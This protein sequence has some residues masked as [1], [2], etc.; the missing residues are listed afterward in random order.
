MR[1]FVAVAALVSALVV[2]AGGASGQIS[3]GALGEQRIALVLA[4]WGPQ[5]VDVAAARQAVDET[6]AFVREASFGKT[7]LSVDVK[8]WLRALTRRP[9]GCDVQGVNETI[10]RSVDL[11]DYDLVAYLVPRL[12]CPW[13]G[14]YYPPGVWMLG[15]ISKNLFAHELGHNWGVREE[16]PAWVCGRPCAA[17]N[18]ADPYSVMG[19][20]S[21]HFGAFEKWRFGWIE[22][23][24]PVLED[25][26]YEIARIDRPSTRPHALYV[27]SGA[28]EYWVEYRPEVPWPVVHAGASTVRVTPSRFPQRNL[29]LA[30]ARSA[31]FAVAGAFEVVRTGADDERM[32]LRFRWTD[33]T[34]PARPRIESRVAGRTVTLRFPAADTGSGVER[35]ELAVGRGIR[36]AVPTSELQ[37]RELVG[38]DAFFRVRLGR[39]AHRV[40]VT[41]IDRAGNRSPTATRTVRIP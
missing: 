40:A 14:A 27:L 1:S 25:G 26:E 5:P 36:V 22:R 20:G 3:D 11:T 34:R 9:T 30:G 21:G 23:V 18:Y 8:G 32:S 4:T 33:R 2:Q 6:A 15:E 37:G 31:R 28:E 13:T 17:E 10:Q 16:G 29:L 12:D 7:W 35:Y 41:A 39:G 24:G 19:H 38:R